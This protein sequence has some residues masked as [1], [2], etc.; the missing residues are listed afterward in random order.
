MAVVLSEGELR[1][2]KK[3]PS[4]IETKVPNEFDFPG[5]V[6]NLS[7]GKLCSS[8]ALLPDVF[9]KTNPEV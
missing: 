5:G 2:I 3:Y 4:R 8:L 1:T 9:S 6:V 7:N